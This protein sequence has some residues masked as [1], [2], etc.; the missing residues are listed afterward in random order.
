MAGASRPCDQSHVATACDCR[1]LRFRI[2]H[3]SLDSAT[4]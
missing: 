2:E 4:K 1:S 3:L